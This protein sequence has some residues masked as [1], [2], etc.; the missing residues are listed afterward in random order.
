MSHE[1]QQGAALPQRLSFTHPELPKFQTAWDSTSIGVA[2]KCPRKYQLSIVEGWG[3][4]RESHHLRYGILYHRALEVYDHK[5][6]EG[7]DHEAALRESLWDLAKGCQDTIEVKVPEDQIA[8]VGDM[9]VLRKQWWNPSEHLGEDKASKN[10]K[11]IPNLF[12]TVVWYLDKF[13]HT[14]PARTL[15][16]ANG[17][18]AVEVSFRFDSGVEVLGH[19]ILLSGHFDRL[20]EFNGMTYVLDRKTTGSTIS[21]SSSFQYFKQYSPNNQMTLYTLASRVALGVPAHGVIIDAA[22]IAMGFSHFERGF[23]NRTNG[24]LDEWLD[25]FRSLVSVFGAYARQ[26]YWPMNDTACSDFGGCPFQGICN[27]DPSVREIFLK[28]D[29]TKKFWDPLQVR[30]DI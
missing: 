14:D 8:E 7:R 17:K 2:K 20:V 30:G 6:A 24:Q 27:R 1:N 21:G 28:S 22:Q 13:G 25:D 16:L 4:R 11:T 10:T 5:I 23:A 26:D 29:F 12:R 9:V 19:P 18:P 3:S 15:V